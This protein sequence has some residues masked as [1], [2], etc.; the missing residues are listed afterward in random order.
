[1]LNYEG[2]KLFYIV[3]SSDMKETTIKNNFFIIVSM[4]SFDLEN[5]ILY[6][7]AMELYIESLLL[8]QN[9]MY[10]YTKRAIKEEIKIQCK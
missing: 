9:K 2:H 6:P 7:K 4:V 8:Q 3:N 1:M 5:T 10:L